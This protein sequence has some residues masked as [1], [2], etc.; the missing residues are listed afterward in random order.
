MLEDDYMEIYTD[1]DNVS[2]T[3]AEIN[4]ILTKSASDENIEH[5][6]E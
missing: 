3:E 2:L 5:D 4:T 6:E 1:E